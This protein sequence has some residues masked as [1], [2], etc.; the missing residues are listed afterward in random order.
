MN[1]KPASSSCYKSEFKS[2]YKRR[3]HNHDYYSAAIYHITISKHFAA[4]YFGHLAGDCRIRPGDT[5]CAYVELN[6]LGRIIQ[7]EITSIHNYHPIVQIYQYSIMPDHIHILLRITEKSPKA[8]GYYIGNLTGAISR[9]WK[10]MTGC[11]FPIFEKGYNDRI[12]YKDRSL[13][14]IFKYIRENPH[15]LAVRKMYPDFFRRV[16]NIT[17]NGRRCQSYGNQFLLRCPF[18]EQV[19]V[20]RADDEAT[21]RVMRER[22]LYAAANGGVLVSPFISPAEKAVRAEAEEAGGRV[23][24]IS[25]NPFAERYKPN[26]RDFDLCCR[27]RLLI[28][29]PAGGEWAGEKV[30]REVCLAMNALAADIYAA[31]A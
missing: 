27:G 8:L 16:R 7:Y 28:V 19:V 2:S 15:R 20:H 14:S 6:D 24:L 29:T 3:A 5:G 11:N 9:R 18:K 21:R 4:P 17:I 25:N 1:H 31:G 23:I 26:V 22:W 12:I 30:S 10:S 13:D